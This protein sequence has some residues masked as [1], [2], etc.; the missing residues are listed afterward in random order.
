T[1]CIGPV[2]AETCRKN[3]IEPDIVAEEYTIS[4]LVEAMGKSLEDGA[5]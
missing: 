3:G 2:T 5:V 4:G 1:A